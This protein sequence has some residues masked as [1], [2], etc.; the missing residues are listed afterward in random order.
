MENTHVSAVPGE[1]VAAGVE[2]D[3]ELEEADMG[4]D[5]SDGD[6]LGFLR[7]CLIT[8]NVSNPRAALTINCRETDIF[9][10][11]KRFTVLISLK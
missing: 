3:E 11:L 5:S 6:S 2:E 10:S 9:N 8:T 1:M 7:P 4:L